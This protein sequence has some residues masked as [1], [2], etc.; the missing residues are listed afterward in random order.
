MHKVFCLILLA[1]SLPS[2]AFDHQFKS[3]QVLL[4]EFTTSKGAQTLVRYRDLKK[5]HQKIDVVLNEFS[6]LKK[7]EFEGFTQEQKLC[8]LINT[9]NLYTLKLVVDHYPVKSIKEIGSIFSS[10]WKKEFIPFLG[11]KISL[12]TIEHEMIRKDFKEPRIHFAVNCASLGCPSLLPSPF[13]A[14]KLEEQLRIV[15]KN[16]LQNSQKNEFKGNILYLSKIFDWYGKDFK[17]M[18]GVTYIEFIKP[19]FPKVKNIEKVEIEFLDYDWSL[20]EAP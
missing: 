10:P 14:D 16:F 19:Y 11:K 1:S 6:K 2:L 8:F 3:Y 17:K 12:D 18:L 7:A 9:Y 4:K 20:N 15:T 13:L 5:S